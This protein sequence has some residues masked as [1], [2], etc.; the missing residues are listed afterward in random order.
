MIIGN[1][2]SAKKIVE[3]DPKNSLIIHHPKPS[4]LAIRQFN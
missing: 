1:I 2:E 3:M 4:D